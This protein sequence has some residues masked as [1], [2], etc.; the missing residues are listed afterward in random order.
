VL[1]WKGEHDGAVYITG[2]TVWYEGVEEVS[3]RFNVRTVLAF[4]GAAV[5]K[6]VGS[7]HLTMT[8]AEAV[9]LA[10][11]FDQAQIIPLHFEGWEHFTES[12]SEIEKAFSDAGLPDR[13]RWAGELMTTT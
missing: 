8:A 2:D 13:L 5:V 1:N 9:E 11:H 3:R 12:R 4:L 7:Y 10:K 6:N